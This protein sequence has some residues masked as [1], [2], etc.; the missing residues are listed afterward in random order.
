MD[1]SNTVGKFD[2]RK[3]ELMHMNRY[4]KAG[5]AMI[6]LSRTLKRPLRI[7]DIGCG[8]IYVMRTFYH[9]FVTKKSDHI[10]EYVGVDIDDKNIAKVESNFSSILKLINGTM[11]C[12]DL[13][14]DILEDY[15]DG[16]FDLIINFEMIEH[17]DP[18]F[19]KGLF[20]EMSRLLSDDG[21]LLLSTPNANGSSPKLP[22]DHFYEYPYAELNKKLSSFFNIFRRTGMSVNLSKV[23]KEQAHLLETY[24]G[25]G[26]T[27]ASVA[28]APMIE[29]VF[30]KNILWEC[31]KKE[32]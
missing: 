6:E 13:T 20:K 17:I 27:F 12:V 25:F 24:I 8:E 19:L 32:V 4:L 15:E 26:K 23:P 1:V 10:E 29:P 16:Y 21:V 22:K 11:L 30:C 18:K 9:S 28:I 3:D 31:S 5:D 7:L 2:I 14:T